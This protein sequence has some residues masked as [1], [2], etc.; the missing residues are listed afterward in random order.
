M[1]A[2]PTR[3]SDVVALRLDKP[4]LQCKDRFPTLPCYPDGQACILKQN[5]WLVGF[6]HKLLMVI[7]LQSHE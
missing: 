5:Q 7:S 3:I 1:T 6:Y 4:L 2:G